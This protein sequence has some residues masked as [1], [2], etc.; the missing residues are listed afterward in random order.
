MPLS[1][2]FLFNNSF[3]SDSKNGLLTS[4]IRGDTEISGYAGNI[5]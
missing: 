4:I 2:L 5:Y 3:V 1:D